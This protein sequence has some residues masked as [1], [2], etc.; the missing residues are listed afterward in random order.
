MTNTKT[1]RATQHLRTNSRHYHILE[2]ISAGDLFVGF[3]TS[4]MST[5]LMYKNAQQRAVERYKN[6]L[7]LERLEKYG[8]IESKRKNSETIYFATQEGKRA[9]HEIYTRTTKTL[10]RPKKWDGMWRVVAYDF[11]ESERSSRNSL[12]YVLEKAEFFQVQKSIWVFP[13]DSALFFQLLKKD[14][15][16][17]AHTIFMKARSI[18]LEIQ[19]KKH[20]HLV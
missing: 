1:Q 18:S 19:C 2:E 15:V 7:A 5:R 11:P 14:E 8:Y 12:R 4:A 17:N 20:F 10:S 6:K 9:L 13:Y 3:L 16:V